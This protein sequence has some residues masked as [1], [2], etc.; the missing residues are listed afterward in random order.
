[1][2]WNINQCIIRLIIDWLKD[3]LEFYTNGTF[4]TVSLLCLQ[5]VCCSYEFK[6]LRKNRRCYVLG[7]HKIN[8][9]MH[10]YRNLAKNEN[11]YFSH[12]QT[13]TISTLSS[14]SS[15]PLPSFSLFSFISYDWPTQ[16]HKN[17]H[18]LGNDIIVNTQKMKKYGKE[19]PW[20]RYV[21]VSSLIRVAGDVAA[22]N[23]Y[24]NLQQVFA[25]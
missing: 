20:L 1:M 5:N 22:F 6:L 13:A 14:C 10:I 12:Q 19:I 21:S 18:I 16:L 15:E 2:K 11:R 4:N 8:H 3:W 24:W 9:L 23:M 25:L 17:I 7:I